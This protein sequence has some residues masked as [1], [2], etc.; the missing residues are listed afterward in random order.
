MMNASDVARA[1][2]L[3]AKT[4]T[5]WATMGLITAHSGHVGKGKARAFDDVTLH[6]VRFLCRA[7]TMGMNI[8]RASA[9]LS[10][11][12]ANPRPGEYLCIRLDY[13]GDVHA[14]V[15]DWSE[16]APSDGDAMMMVSLT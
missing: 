12:P 7:S 4:I 15:M 3:S 9:F 13:N 8:T 6:H 2:G 11:I 16:I 1:V 10:L 5:D 14:A